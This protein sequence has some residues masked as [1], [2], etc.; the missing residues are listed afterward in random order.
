MADRLAGLVLPDTTP[1]EAVDDNVLPERSERKPRRNPTPIPSAGLAKR[2]GGLRIGDWLLAAGGIALAGIC[3]V[4]PWYIFFHQE[5][6]GIRPLTFS[7][8]RGGRGTPGTDLR[9]E[10]LD[11][12]AELGLEGM[13]Q[14]DFAPTGTVPD[15]PMQMSASLREQPFPGDRRNFHFIAAENGRGI[16]EDDDGFWMVQ[17]GSLLPDGSRVVRIEQRPRTWVLVTSAETEIP[18]AR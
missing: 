10:Y 8:Q 7:E 12:Q 18:L 2:I 16:I 11:D 5:H 13:P 3:A 6:F 9:Q 1:V 14:L 17:P 4:F 15:R